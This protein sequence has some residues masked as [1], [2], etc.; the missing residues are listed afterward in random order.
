MQCFA[1]RMN[2]ASWYLL[3]VP[4]YLWSISQAQLPKGHTYENVHTK[5]EVAKPD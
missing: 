1:P 3:S 4:Q 2:A 5:A